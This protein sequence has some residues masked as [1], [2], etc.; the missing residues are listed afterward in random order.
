MEAIIMDI[1]FEIKLQLPFQK[2]LSKVTEALKKE[3]FGVLT[4]IDV[5]SIL[6]D[7]LGEAFRPYAIL[8]AC[9][10]PLAH[11]ALSH[12][13]VVGLLLPCNITVEAEGETGSIV[14]IINPEVMM[15]VGH[16]QGDDVLL[17][18]ATEA[19]TRLERVAQSLME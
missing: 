2:A 4:Q 5:Q 12:D 11:R 10:P 7:K 18:V 17:E 6:K 14:R 19:R 16:L 8:G 3:G 9:N 15:T 1:G 13:G